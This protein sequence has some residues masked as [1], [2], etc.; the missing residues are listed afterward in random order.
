M[1]Q[2]VIV[3]NDT[4]KFSEFAKR[5]SADSQ[6]RTHWASS[7]QTALDVALSI[8]PDLM[9]I[10]ETVGGQMGIDIARKVILKNAFI[11]LA[12]ASSL[13]PEEFHEVSEGLG[14]M[15]Q[16]P[17]IPNKS[18]AERLLAAMASLK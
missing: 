12:V 17:L 7:V 10:D 15:A 6:C 5:L 16:L 3:T 2:I 11:N 13:K 9:I 14:I 8:P 4:N 18:D 1:V